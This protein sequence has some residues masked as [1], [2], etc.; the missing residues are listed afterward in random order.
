MSPV[1]ITALEKR[2]TRK[3]IGGSN[4]PASAAVENKY[5]RLAHLVE[6]L[7]DVE[8][9]T[10]SILVPPTDKIYVSRKNNFDNGFIERYRPRDCGTRRLVGG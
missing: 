8:E 3:G 6:R 10:S 2:H 9:V 1:E 7:V 4:P 5:G